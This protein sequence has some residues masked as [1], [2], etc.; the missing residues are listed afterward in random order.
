M[1]LEY[2]NEDLN[3][4]SSLSNRP[5]ETEPDELTPQ[6]FKAKFDEA[7]NI[8]KRYI[9]E[10]FIPSITASSI[11][12]SVTDITASNV[13]EALAF[14]QKNFVAEEREN[15]P[16][17]SVDRTKLSEAVRDLLDSGTPVVSAEDP[18]GNYPIGQIWLKTNGDGAMEAMYIKVSATDWVAYTFD[19]L[20]INRGGTG[21]DRVKAGAMLYG[22]NGDLEQ[23]AAPPENSLLHFGTKPEWKNRQE[24]KQQLGFLTVATG[25]YRGTGKKGEVSLVPTGAEDAITPV[26]ICVYR[27]DGFYEANSEY[28]HESSVCLCNGAEVHQRM[29]LGQK[30]HFITVKL[31][32]SELVFDNKQDSNADALAALMNNINIEYCWTALY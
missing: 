21:L 22:N 29:Y 7:A 27:K 32:G 20:P 28:N 31:Q 25:E 19:V 18:S 14:L 10:R 8:I 23:L 12:C 11:P 24:T 9:N 3:I 5:S 16:E 1:G 13:S 2:L 15:I 30:V 6:E 26:M 17:N 4:I